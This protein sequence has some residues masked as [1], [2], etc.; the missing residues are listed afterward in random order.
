ML[1]V[2][3]LCVDDDPAIRTT[4]PLIFRAHGYD[5]TSV[6]TV[7][8]ALCEIA[9]RPFD[10]LI[11]DLNIGQQGDG[12]TVVSAM[13]RTHPDCINFIV[14]GY[15][16]IEDALR[17]ISSQVDEV[18][19]KPTNTPNMVAAVEQRLRER[20]PIGAIQTK[21]IS[22]LLSDQ[23]DEICKRILVEMKANPELAAL[24]LSDE[25]R[26]D[27]TRIT[28][29]ELVQELD[30]RSQQATS[31]PAAAKTGKAR[32]VQQYPIALL[33]VNARLLQGVI[34]EIIHENLLLINLSYLMPDL[35]RLNEILSLQSEEIV[36]QFLESEK[37]AA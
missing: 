21:R 17:A 25:E 30:S 8:E 6:G 35:K 19:I 5:A 14:T 37:H 13:R 20:T 12:F 11:S 15:P 9:A 27:H 36:R 34:Y 33:A 28:L 32:H 23:K 4:M 26:L 2:R 31:L 10:V 3:V 16:A 24:P 7:A 22:N 18:L 1:P 29:T